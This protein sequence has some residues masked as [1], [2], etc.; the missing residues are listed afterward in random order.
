MCRFIPQRWWNWL[1]VMG[2]PS[3]HTRCRG[4]IL[5]DGVTVDSQANVN[6]SVLGQGAKV[7]G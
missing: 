2:F 6:A 3:V 7:G 1:S 5:G 4:S